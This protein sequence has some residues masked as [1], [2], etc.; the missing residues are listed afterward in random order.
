MSVKLE[1]L[2]IRQMRHVTTFSFYTI[3]QTRS[4]SRRLKNNDYQDR[5]FHGNEVT[6]QQVD[7]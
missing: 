4:G 1:R 7:K 5:I 2:N 3:I 6:V